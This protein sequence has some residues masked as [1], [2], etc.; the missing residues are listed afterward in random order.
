MGKFCRH[1]IFSAMKKGDNKG[2]SEVCM[3]LL[4]Y[5]TKII[6]L[7]YVLM[8]SVCKS[9]RVFPIQMVIDHHWMVIAY[10]SYNQ[11]DF[12]TETPIN[13]NPTLFARSKVQNLM[14]P[15]H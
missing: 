15:Y 10:N 11:M 6:W 9:L 8:V 14:I 5:T 1:T 3:V 2:T 4:E 12:T 7:R 13:S